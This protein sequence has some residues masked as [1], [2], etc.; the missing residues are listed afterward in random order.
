MLFSLKGDTFDLML[1]QCCSICTSIAY[2]HI[3]TRTTPYSVHVWFGLVVTFL[4][5]AVPR[6]EVDV[7]SIQGGI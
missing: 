4:T 3:C 1:G 2:L 5:G 6:R 7:E